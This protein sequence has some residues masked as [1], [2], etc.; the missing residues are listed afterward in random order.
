MSESQE[1]VFT[2]KCHLEQN[3]KNYYMFKGN[4]AKTSRQNS[5]VNGIYLDKGIFNNNL[6]PQQIEVTFAWSDADKVDDLLRGILGQP[7]QDN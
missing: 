4:D 1:R 2:V 6:P 3:F 5:K 7:P